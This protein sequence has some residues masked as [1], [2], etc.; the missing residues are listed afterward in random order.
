MTSFA[1]IFSSARHLLLLLLLLFLPLLVHAHIGSPNIFFDGKA[2]AYDV[3]LII[4]PP[5]ALPGSAQVDVRVIGA[6]AT[7]IWLQPALWEAG[8]DAAPAPVLAGPVAGETNLFNGAVWLMRPGSYSLCVNL[9]GPSGRGKVVVPINSAATQR[10]TMGPTLRTCLFA[11]GF[12]LFFG[13][14]WIV[15]A[16]ARDTALDPGSLPAEWDRKRAKLVATTTAVVLLAGTYAGAMRWRSM[17]GEF[18]N[19]ALAKPLPVV[20][21]VHTNGSLQLLRLAPSSDTRPGSGW[22]TLVADH[23][24]LMHLFLIHA[25][26]LNAF[27]HLHPVR[28]D[29][30]SFENVLPPLPGGPYL[31][32]AEV[33]HE[34]GINETLIANLNLQSSTGR[35]PQRTGGT[36]MLNEILCQS[37]ILLGTNSPQPFALDMDDSWHG[38]PSSGETTSLTSRLMN[39]YT[40]TFANRDRLI[41]NRE[42]SLRFALSDADERPAIL[43]PYMGML[44]HAVVRR[45]DGTVFTHLHPMGTI[46]MAA[47]ALLA[48]REGNAT[49]LA[50]ANSSGAAPALDATNEVSFP[51]AFPRPGNYRVWVQV[52]INFRVFTGV[53]DLHVS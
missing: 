24:K 30:A 9:E 13:A 38:S 20:A 12:I 4:R 45:S 16:A 32:Y 47:Q 51:Y 31:V 26:D 19:N 17:D 44:G 53:F 35:A 49:V 42:L 40:M 52:R 7:K 50:T 10:P 3:R 23:G 33:T 46:S 14:I 39:G 6:P 48:Q 34:N 27:A 37:A 2:G 5:A 22:D 21:T 25:P 1:N 43:Q 28:R 41:E 15:G 8:E 36:N 11:L 18:R 29:A